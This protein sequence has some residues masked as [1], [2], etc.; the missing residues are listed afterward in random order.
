MLLPLSVNLVS[1]CCINCFKC[2]VLSS[3]RIAADGQRE[4]V[5][6]QTQLLRV[7]VK[8]VPK[9]PPE[10][11]RK[12]AYKLVEH[13]RFSWGIM[14]CIVLNTVRFVLTIMLTDSLCR[15]SLLHVSDPWSFLAV[16]SL[17]G[18]TVRILFRDDAV[19]CRIPGDR[20][21]FV[22]AGVYGRSCSQNHR[23]WDTYLLRLGLEPVLS[24]QKRQ[25]S[26]A[27]F[28]R[29]CCCRCMIHHAG[30]TFSS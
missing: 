9:M 13:H 15:L 12:T 20:Q 11:W 18:G 8:E 24:S 28:L 21:R 27:I 30:S 2:V 25:A 22:C 5:K 7:K 4:W 26:H 1:V 6:V 14:T 23:I 19:V 17:T 10:P 16:H 29:V 3:T